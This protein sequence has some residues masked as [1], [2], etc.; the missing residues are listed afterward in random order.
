MKAL[1]WIAVLAFAGV[2]GGWIR[3]AVRQVDERRRAEEARLADFMAQAIARPAAPPDPSAAQQKLLFDAAAKTAEAGEPALAIQLYARLIAR[4][5][6]SG[7]A[8]ECRVAVEALKAKI[9]ISKA[10]GPAGPG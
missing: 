5:P 8:G 6:Q 3:H 4:Y 9:A 7:L 2:A 10:P 1:F